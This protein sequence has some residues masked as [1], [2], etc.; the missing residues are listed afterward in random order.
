MPL[1]AARRGA[2]VPGVRTVIRGSPYCLELSYFHALGGVDCNRFS[3]SPTMILP[4]IRLSGE[5]GSPRRSRWKG[6]SQDG[7]G[8][9]FEV[10]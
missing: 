5:A 8:S 2:H 4:G 1:E 3:L 6:L 9:V 7:D 10:I